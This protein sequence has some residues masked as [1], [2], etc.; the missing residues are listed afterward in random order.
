MKARDSMHVLLVTRGLGVRTFVFRR[1]L[2]AEPGINDYH[3]LLIDTAHAQMTGPASS[4]R[5]GTLRPLIATLG[6]RPRPGET[7]SVPAR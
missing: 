7:E 6:R 5:V 2:F 4:S 3:C 1:V